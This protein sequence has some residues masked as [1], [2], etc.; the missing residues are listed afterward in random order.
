MKEGT[1]SDLSKIPSLLKEYAMDKPD[2]HLIQG[3]E[4][5]LSGSALLELMQGVLAKGMPFRFQARGWSMTPFIRD[6]D[7]IL[8]APLLNTKPRLGDVLAVRHP[9][10]DKLIVHRVIGKNDQAWLI[11]GDNLSGEGDGWVP[12]EKIMGRVTRVERNGK[13]VWLGLGP[14][15]YGIAL[16]SRIGLFPFASKIVT[17]FIKS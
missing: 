4:M 11:Q 17:H 9:K 16:F 2:L 15:R 14:E 5:A 6:G 1:I 8:I 3:K 13:K 10:T 12:M 7:V